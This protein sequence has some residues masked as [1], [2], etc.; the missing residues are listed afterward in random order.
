MA[1]KQVRGEEEAMEVDEEGREGDEGDGE[2][3]EGDD[4]GQDL[5]DDLNLDDAQEVSHLAYD[6]VI[7][8]HLRK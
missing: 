4:E 2:K 3:K 8:Q 6:G 7:G 1:L 5:P